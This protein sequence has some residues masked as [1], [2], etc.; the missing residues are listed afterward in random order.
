MENFFVNLIF[1]NLTHSKLNFTGSIQFVLAMGNCV[2]VS[3]NS[4]PSSTSYMLKWS[5]SVLVPIMICRLFDTKPLPWTNTDFLSVGLLGSIFV[6]I[7]IKKINQKDN[8]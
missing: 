5:G 3:F 7:E 6:K 1:Y 2:A 4:S 8:F